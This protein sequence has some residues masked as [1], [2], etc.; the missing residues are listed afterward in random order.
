MKNSMIKKLIAGLMLTTFM[1]SNGLLTSLAMEDAAVI[2]YGEAGKPVLLSSET[3][4]AENSDSKWHKMLGAGG[5]D[6]GT[7]VQ[8]RAEHINKMVVNDV[9]RSLLQ[10][11]VQTEKQE[12]D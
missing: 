5:N 6:P 12:N 11:E 2:Q 10:E 3:T 9:V 1:L 4:K 8:Q 7:D